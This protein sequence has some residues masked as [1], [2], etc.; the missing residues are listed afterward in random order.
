MDCPLNGAQFIGGIPF[1][2]WMKVFVHLPGNSCA[3]HKR[4]YADHKHRF[5]DHKSLCADHKS[6]FADHKSS[7]A[8]HKTTNDWN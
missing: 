1:L 8:D 7:Y 6:R 2:F 4:C 5:T 3:D